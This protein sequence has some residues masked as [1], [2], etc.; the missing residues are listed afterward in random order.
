MA[1]LAVAVWAERIAKKVEEFAAGIPNRGLRLVEGEPK[2]GHHLPRPRQRLCRRSAAEDDEVVGIGDD[3]GLVGL[4]PPRCTPMLQETVHVQVGEQW[5]YH[6]TLRRAD[7]T[8]LAP[9]HAPPHVI[10]ALLSCPY[11]HLA[12]PFLHT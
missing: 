3:P 10:L 6:P 11:L 1:I 2:L 12:E 4:A 9:V 7:G 5:A 8:P